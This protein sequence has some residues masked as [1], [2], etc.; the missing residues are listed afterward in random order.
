MKLEQLTFTRFLA[1][2]AIVI[3]HYGRNIFPFNHDAVSF[4][5]TQADVG[6]SYFFILSGFVMIIA[7][8]SKDKIAFGDYV[9]KR[10]ARL[11]PVYALAIFILLL[12]FIV[13]P[14]GRIDYKGFL[15]NLTLLQSWFPGYALS[16]N[17]PGWSLSTEMF[18][19]LLFPV[20][21]NR[22]YKS[23]SLKKIAAFVFIVFVLSQAL[24]HALLQST[25]YK[26]YPTP[27]YELLYC[28]PPMHIN[29]FLVGNLAG[30]FF[31]NGNFKKGNY[32]L[33]I[34]LL[35]AAVCFALKFSFGV[36]YHNGMLALLFVPLIIF[37]SLNSG[38]LTKISNTRL[39]VFLGEI[40]YGIYIL[41]FPVFL[42]GAGLFKKFNL[43]CSPQLFFLINFTALILLSIMSYKYVEI[44]MRKRISNLKLRVSL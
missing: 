44:P 28:F 38:L 21:F 32:D 41:Q 23:L 36:V 43:S 2:I 19:Y 1:A 25:F 7:Y 34:L 11:Y 14:N 40:S 8:N 10:L 15:L 16:F 31:L 22:V 33:V 39:F 24:F 35:T 29:E 27:S 17:S 42:W 13:S 26:G 18:F 12:Y 4:L 20:L 5:V 3:F 37:T 9:Q 6:V 30:L